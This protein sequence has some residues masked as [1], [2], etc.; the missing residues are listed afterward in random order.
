M[1]RTGL[2]AMARRQASNTNIP[3]LRRNFDILMK[4]QD[5]PPPAK[6]QHAS[7]AAVG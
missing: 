6:R 4:T 1:I 3:E 5:Q 7:V 2:G